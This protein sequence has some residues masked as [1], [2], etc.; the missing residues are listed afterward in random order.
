MFKVRWKGAVY[1]VYHVEPRPILQFLVYAPKQGIFG[2]KKEY[3]FQ[4]IK[5]SECEEVK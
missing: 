2:A 5:A 3:E 4:Y 1:T